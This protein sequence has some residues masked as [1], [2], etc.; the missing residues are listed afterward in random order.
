MSAIYGAID[1]HGGKIDESYKDRFT[2]KFANCRIDRYG[3]L[4]HEN[5]YMSCGIQYF[6]KRAE[7]EKLPIHDA[8]D[9]F[10]TADC[11]ID[12]RKTL[13]KELSLDNDVADGDIILA[14]YRK[15]GKECVSHFEGPFSFVIYDKSK[16]EIM[17]AAD[18]FS[19]RCLFYHERNGVLYFSTL[20]F[21]IKEVSGLE[22]EKNDRWLIDA[23]SVI[24][25]TV[26]SEPKETALKDVFKVVCG[27]YI[28][29]S[30]DK[31]GKTIVS[32]NR[33]YD[34]A[35]TIPT[36][37]SITHSQSEE[38]VREVMNGVIE[39][40]LDEQDNVAAQISS[41]LDS[42]TVA[43][44]A[45]RILSKRGG[46]IHGYT[47]VPLKE[48]NLKDT[49]WTV[50]DETEGAKKVY[51]M[52]PNIE[53]HFVDSAGRSFLMEAEEHIDYLELPCKSQQNAIWLDEI[54]IQASREGARILLN[55]GTG[56]STISAGDFG[57]ILYYYVTHFK[58]SKA[59]KVLNRLKA[60][61][62]G[63]KKVVK[64]MIKDV[65]G[66]Y[67]WYFKPEEKDCYLR[68]VTRKDVG[69]KVE[70]TKRFRKS[71]MHYYPYRDMKRMR[72]I[73]YYLD[74]YSQI[75]EYDTKA[76]LKCG[77]LSRDPMCSVQLVDLCCKLPMCC[78]ADSDYDR[79]LCRAGMRG[80]VPD[81]I[82][83]N[84]THRG[85]Q[86]GDN[87]YRVA[88]S[89]NMVRDKWIEKVLSKDVLEYLSEEKIKKILDVCDKG[90]DKADFSSV[91][92]LSNLYA[93][94]LYLEKLN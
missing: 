8:D 37:W 51:S 91:Y 44:I 49:G 22:F 55:G 50:Y 72:K 79:R 52:Y 19:Q 66:Y 58:L 21:P 87:N 81:E 40:I 6:Y 25:P 20:F 30:L 36:D 53:P 54:N 10:L 9:I 16:N 15:W 88:Q 61:G 3:H 80:I 92:Q 56:N 94:A 42:T 89:W 74:A 33:Y 4:V 46:K 60:L 41:G 73:F 69:E 75:G 85:S 68:N 78:Y 35:R 2:E 5:V 71:F 59:K 14:G 24:G 62:S 47:S 31:N 17:V 13:I 70:L 38:M 28:L 90:I 7:R 29:F 12:N 48:A 18:Q 26:I 32:E 65:L 45:A 67:T 64:L 1:L 84:M 93:F 83:D 34:P 11:V 63:R 23:I 39:K 27:T 76:S 82:L 86:S 57:D 77:I 43:C